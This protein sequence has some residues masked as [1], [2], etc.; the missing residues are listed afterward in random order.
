MW[1]GPLDLSGY[2][3]A[4]RAYVRA[5]HKHSKFNFGV[6]NFS[7]SIALSMID[8]MQEDVELWERLQHKY[9]SLHDTVG[10]FHSVPFLFPKRMFSRQAGYTVYES[11]RQAKMRLIYCNEMDEIWVPCGFNRDTFGR[12]G[13]HTPL[14]VVPH[15]VDIDMYDPDNTEPYVFDEIKDKYVFLAMGDFHWRKGWDVLFEAYWKAFD[16]KD[17]VV[18][19][20]KPFSGDDSAKNQNRLK[21]LIRDMKSNKKLEDKDTAPVAFFG[22]FVTE[23]E[24]RGLYKAA[25]CYVSTTRGEAWGLHLSEA[26]A[27][28]VP[29]V[30][31]RWGGQSE[32]LDDNN[33]YNVKINGLVP[34]TDPVLLRIEPGYYKHNMADPN[35]D[36]AVEQMRYVYEHQD[37][38]KAKAKYGRMDLHQRFNP[39]RIANLIDRRVEAL[40]ET[41]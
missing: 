41:M 24:M 13:V 11:D 31:T 39:K 26:L 10:I 25:D 6:R 33:S 23:E 1:C 22:K 8:Q 14:H 29:V 16:S 32:Y 12:S 3:S 19:L 21:Q 34:V 9:A 4:S 40:M 18:L 15:V 30:A 35:V 17:D 28:E 38:A 5:L 36:H 2:G 37:E 20:V 7:S 27:M